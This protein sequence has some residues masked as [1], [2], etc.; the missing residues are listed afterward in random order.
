MIFCS[1]WARPSGLRLWCGRSNPSRR[2]CAAWRAPNAA[3]AWRSTR[4]RSPTCAPPSTPR[5]RRG[6]APGCWSSRTGRPRR[7]WEPRSRAGYS[8]G[9]PPAS[10]PA[11]PQ[12]EALAGKAVPTSR[13]TLA[14]ARDLTIGAF[15]RQPREPDEELAG[16]R[17]RFVLIGAALAATLIAAG[18]FWFL[19]YGRGG[20][21]TPASRP[22][23]AAPA[24]ATGAT[25]NASAPAAPAPSLLLQGKADELLEK[26]RLAMHERRYTEPAADNAL[27]YYRSAAAADAANVKAPDRLQRVAGRLAALLDTALAVVHLRVHRLTLANLK[28]APATHPRSAG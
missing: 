15:R 22:A 13:T 27:L 2:P 23:A 21:V 28:A 3:R 18:A 17:P 24:A 6:R 5:R 10:S 9:W 8:R 1:N 4:A 12:P 14:A 7:S 16:S 25:D 11:R 19:M 26:A 20:P